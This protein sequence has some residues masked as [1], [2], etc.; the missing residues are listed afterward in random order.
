MSDPYFALD[1]GDES[2]NSTLEIGGYSG[3]FV[4]QS[5]CRDVDNH[6][7]PTRCASRPP[8]RSPS[9]NQIKSNQCN[10]SFH[11]T[12][13]I[14]INTLHYI[15]VPADGTA[16]DV[17]WGQAQTAAKPSSWGFPAFDLRV[18]ERSMMGN[19][20]SFWPAVVSTGSACLGLPEEVMR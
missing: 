5:R 6:W 9:S 3:E 15:T 17:E 2:Y 10:Q 7:L 8:E 11:E 13:P 20:T 14:E 12:P 4:L 1:L 19:I 16:V 18:C